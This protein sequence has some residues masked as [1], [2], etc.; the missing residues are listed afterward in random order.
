MEIGGWG[1]Q[2]G[3]IQTLMQRVKE[4]GEKYNLSTMVFPEGTRSRSGH[5]Q[6]FKDGFFRFAIDNNRRIL[7]C[8]ER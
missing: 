3:A 5:L 7:P 4:M 2:P 8:G 6:P 1:T